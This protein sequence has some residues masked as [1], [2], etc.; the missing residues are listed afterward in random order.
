[1]SRF[2]TAKEIRAAMDGL[3]D[4][5]VGKRSGSV[6]SWTDDNVTQFAAG[7]QCIAYVDKNGRINILG[8]GAPNS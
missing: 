3:A 2:R 1:M 5:S 4:G 7:S 6:D 8:D